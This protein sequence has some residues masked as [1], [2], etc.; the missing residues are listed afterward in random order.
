MRWA[1]A[2]AF[3]EQ[4]L[5]I[6]EDMREVN[7]PLLVL[8]DPADVVVSYKGSQRLCEVCASKDARLVDVRGGKH[9]IT[10]NKPEVVLQYILQWLG[11]HA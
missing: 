4:Y 8:H 1:T 11:E 2:N 7:A 9:D 3:A 5:T 6:D 10:M